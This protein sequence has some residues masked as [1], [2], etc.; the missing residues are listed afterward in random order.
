M[1]TRE[2]DDRAD[3]KFNILEFGKHDRILRCG[4]PKRQFCFYD[5][6]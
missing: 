1:R 3:Q 6:D 2:V 4:S 5:N